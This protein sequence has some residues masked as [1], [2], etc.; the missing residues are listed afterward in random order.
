MKYEITFKSIVVEAKT[1]EEAEQ[2]AVDEVV[3]GNLEVDEVNECE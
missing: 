2:K 3:N 1:F